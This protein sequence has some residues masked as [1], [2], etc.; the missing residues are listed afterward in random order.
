VASSF[1]A[2]SPVYVLVRWVEFLALLVVVGTAA[3][4]ATVLGVRRS[5]WSSRASLRVAAHRRSAAIGLGASLALVLTALVRLYA[6]SYAIHGA[7][8]ALEASRIVVMLT[9]TAWGWGWLLQ[10]SAAFVAV[11]GYRVARGQ[12]ARGWRIATAAA[13]ALSFTPALAGHAVAAER[14]TALAVLTDGVH[15][16][17][18]AGWLGSLLVM[19][20]AGIGSAVAVE[21]KSSGPAV[22]ELVN[23]FSPTALTFA[24]LALLTGLVSAW[25]NLGSLSALW[26]SRYGQV[27][28][29]KLAA[30]SVVAGTGAYNWLRVRP[31]LG[32]VAGTNRLRR[33][34]SAEL[35]AG[36]IVLFVTAV[37]VATPR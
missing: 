24:A 35:A 4:Q 2:E 31:A 9:R 10:I 18:A 37:L 15:V 21:G 7:A 5:L 3:F 27:L 32:E 17:G 36:V 19:V 6:Q 12:G 34:A 8:N 16:L 1:T 28:L 33:S 25:L 29:V 14:L 23:A 26:T 13:V 22:A 20:T 11:A 30:L